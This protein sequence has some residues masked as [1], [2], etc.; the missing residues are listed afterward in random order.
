MV[1]RNDRVPFPRFEPMIARNPAVVF[2]LL[3]IALLPLAERG[4]PN[5]SPTQQL[6]LSE[7]GLLRPFIDVIDDLITSFVGN[8][9]LVQSSPLSFFA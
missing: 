9:F 4:R 8:P 6:S 1:E 5:A 7:F 3:A 2:K